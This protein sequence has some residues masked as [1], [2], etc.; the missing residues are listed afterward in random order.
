MYSVLD[1]KTNALTGAEMYRLA[2][3]YAG[4]LGALAR[5]PL[6]RFHRRIASIPFRTDAQIFTGPEEQNDEGLKRPAMLLKEPALDCKKKNLLMGAWAKQN[7]VP[8]R[9]VA[10]SEKRNGKIHHVMTQLLL[11]GQWTNADATLPTD[12]IG[13]AKPGVTRAMELLR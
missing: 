10:I 7:G 6:Q 8:F 13:G 2:D 12:R 5:M 1:G 3:T 11:N 4:D 9:F